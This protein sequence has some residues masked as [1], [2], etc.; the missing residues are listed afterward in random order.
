MEITVQVISIDTWWQNSNDWL[1][2]APWILNDHEGF[3]KTDNS[4]FTS[5]NPCHPGSRNSP[6]LVSVYAFFLQPRS[7]A[8]KR[9]QY[10]SVVKRNVLC[11]SDRD[12][13][14]FSDDLRR[15]RSF[16]GFRSRTM[17]RRE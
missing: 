16:G 7:C 4:I 11:W 15:D 8:L 14:D 9:Q 3:V 10:W 1:S 12:W 13:H 5:P 17:C 6:S 2:T